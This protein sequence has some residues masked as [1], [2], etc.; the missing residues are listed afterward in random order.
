MEELV[1]AGGVGLDLSRR[2]VGRWG[3][4]ARKPLKSEHVSLIFEVGTFGGTPRALLGPPGA[5][6]RPRSHFPGPLGA[7]FE[8][9]MIHFRTEFGSRGVVFR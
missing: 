5:P 7:H 2:D 6:V 4:G 1:W 8:V 3:P 9:L